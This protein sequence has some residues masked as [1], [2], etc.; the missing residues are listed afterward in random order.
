MESGAGGKGQESNDKYE[1]FTKI[2][3][4]TIIFADTRVIIVKGMEVRSEECT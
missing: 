3:D 4:L 1:C 2:G